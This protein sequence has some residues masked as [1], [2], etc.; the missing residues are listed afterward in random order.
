MSTETTASAPVTAMD[1]G[2]YRQNVMKTLSIKPAKMGLL[3]VA[4]NTERSI[5]Q[6]AIDGFVSEALEF[7]A[8][9]R[10]F[11]LGSQLNKIDKF[12]PDG[13]Q[14]ELGDCGYYLAVLAKATKSK[15]FSARKKVK[16]T[17]TLTEAILDF[18]S[19]AEHLADLAKKTY[20]GPVTTMAEKPSRNPKT[21]E[22]ST[23]LV[24][25]LD[26]PAEALAWEERKA[27]IVAALAVAAEAHARL[28]LAIL[29]TT[30][31]PV[32]LANIKKL[33]ARFP[34]GTFTLVAVAK[35]DPEA[36][37]EAAQAPEAVAA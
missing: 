20:Y 33:Q 31:G 26:K 28:C 27:K 16:L 7:L 36:E 10:P 11:M 5:I 23:K 15:A 6:H 4:R 22:V 12:G 21:G 18:M 34:E 19:S 24:P 8:S 25:V 2:L 14:I 30:T 37:A 32:N 3:V 29:G 35:K 9:M 13:P 17:G 1:S